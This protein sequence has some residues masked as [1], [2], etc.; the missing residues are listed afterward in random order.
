MASRSFFLTLALGA[1]LAVFGQRVL[2][3]PR[4]KIFHRGSADR[5][6]VARWVP[7][8]ERGEPDSTLSGGRR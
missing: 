4:Y 8:P 6:T 3:N 5:A 1:L 7:N 2:E